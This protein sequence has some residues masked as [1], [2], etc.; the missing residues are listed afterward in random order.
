[1]GELLTNTRSQ[2]TATTLVPEYT[3]YQAV[4]TST[5]ALFRGAHYLEPN[6]QE[7]PRSCSPFPY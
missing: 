3:F 4:T 2:T 7:N 6:P 1:M 5:R